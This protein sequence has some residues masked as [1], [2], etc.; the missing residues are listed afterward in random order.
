MKQK[1]MFTNHPGAA[2][3]ELAAGMSPSKV[4]V[5]VDTNTEKQVLPLL[6]VMS[7]SV[8]GAQVITVGAGDVNKNLD[9]LAGIW[10]TLNESGATRSSFVINVGGGMVTDM[11]GFA[12]ATFKRGMRFVNVPTTLLAAVD[13]SVGGKTGINFNGCKNEVGAFAE[14]EAAVISTIFFNTL[15]T[16]ELLSGYAE[17]LKHAL[18][19][20]RQTFIDLLDYNFAGT[21]FDKDRLLTLLQK[22]VA[23]KER[24]VSEDLHEQGIRK[25]LNLGHTVGHAFESYAMTDRHSPVPHGYAVAWGM[26][27]ELILSHMELK[28]PS[29]MLQR[30]AA[31]VRSNYGVFDIT[32]DDYPALLKLMSH[33]KKNAS[34][35][36]INFTLLADIGD[37]RIDREADV[38]NIKAALDIYRDMMGI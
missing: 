35:D 3:D 38:D 20:D 30:Y 1:L 15:T 18:L 4:F 8:A 23:V 34:A 14:P 9:S 26:V 22:S 5:I 37:V 11:G 12:A 28:F 29:D 10:R 13:A 6:A 19:E 36:R 31:Y 21:G 32:C 16:Q 17:M 27:V 2:I 25:A 24:I 33:D 7:E